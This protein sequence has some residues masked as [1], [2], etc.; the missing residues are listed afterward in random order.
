MSG[1]HARNARTVFGYGI[2]LS[3]FVLEYAQTLSLNL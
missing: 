2:A 3:I 1:R